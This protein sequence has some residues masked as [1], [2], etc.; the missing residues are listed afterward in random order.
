MVL[1]SEQDY[2]SFYE[3]EAAFRRVQRMP[4]YTRLLRLIYTHFDPVRSQ[5]EAE[6]LG[7]LLR[8]ERSDWAMTEVD[9]LGP[10]PAY[11]SRVRGRYRW[12]ILLR[13]Q[14]PRLLLDRVLDKAAL[15][16]GWV[17]DVDPVSVL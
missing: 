15:R 8:K 5:R 12:H 17:V 9:V 1:A 6:R 7:R 14:E 16:D 3:Q 10:A 4:P 13:G 2:A 11:N